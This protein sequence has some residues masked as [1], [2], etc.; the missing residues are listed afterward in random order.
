M[1]W[2]LALVGLIMIAGCAPPSPGVL[3]DPKLTPGE[4]I[5]G[6]TAAQVCES[7][8][9]SANVAVPDADRDAIFAAYGVSESALGSYP[10]DHLVSLDLGGTNSK[11]NLWPQPLDRPGFAGS[12]TKDG[13]ESH[14]HEL[15]CSG[16]LDLTTAQ[17][18]IA[19][20]WRIALARYRANP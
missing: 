11:A 5:P 15:V 2:R 18:A 6:V 1:R 4:A 16:R 3:P 10:L 20:D 14:L 13:L 8:W 19:S 12:Q 17:R 9:A 7:G